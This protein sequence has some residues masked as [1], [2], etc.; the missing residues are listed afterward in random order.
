MAGICREII[1]AVTR[2]PGWVK[3]RKQRLEL[4]GGKCRACGKK[5]IGLQV[6][7]IE[8]FH[9]KP[10]LELDIENTITHCGRCT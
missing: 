6:H 3:I 10:E 2:S 7:H 1:K 9:L 8:P 5:S 4:D